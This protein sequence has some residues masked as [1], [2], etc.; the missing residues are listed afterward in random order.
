MNDSPNKTYVDSMVTGVTLSS[1]GMIVS[2]GASFYSS[3]LSPEERLELMTLEK[4]YKA[5]VKNKRITI[6]KSMP[7]SLRQ[8]VVDFIMYKKFLDDM[9]NL[10][11]DEPEWS[12]LYDL[13][14]R[15]W[16]DSRASMTS[17]LSVCVD[18][19]Y[20]AF[21]EFLTEEEVFNAHA[22]QSLE[23]SLLNTKTN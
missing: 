2:S 20:E 6:F 10:P 8:S 17:G 14:R 21:L 19:S 3:M 5:V 9:K 7:S 1:A 22:E 16:R 15:D 12:R 18:S 4:E 11:E 13:R 23:E